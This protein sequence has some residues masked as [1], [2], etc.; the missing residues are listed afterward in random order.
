MFFL[1]EKYNNDNISLTGFKIQDFFDKEFITTAITIYKT[2]LNVNSFLFDDEYNIFLSSKKH[3]SILSNFLLKDE[4]ILKQHIKNHES[5]GNLNN[6]D[7]IITDLNGFV[8]GLI[9]ILVQNYK[10]GTFVIVDNSKGFFTY[11]KIKYMCES[12]NIKY[13]KYIKEYNFLS[14]Y[15]DERFNSIVKLYS[16]C[17]CIKKSSKYLHQIMNTQD[18]L[19]NSISSSS[20]KSDIKDELTSACKTC[21]EILDIDISSILL[22]NINNSSFEFVEESYNYN[23]VLEDF[24]NT[25]VKNDTLNI[26]DISSDIETYI[27]EKNFYIK[28][29]N[30]EVKNKVIGYVFLIKANKSISIN[31]IELSMLKSIIKLVCINYE[32]KIADSDITT[33]YF[34]NI[35]DNMNVGIYIK[36]CKSGEIVYVNKFF[37]NQFNISSHTENSNL[38]TYLNLVTEEGDFYYNELDKW[39]YNYKFMTKWVD[40]REV[41]L[42]INIE[43]TDA[44]KKHLSVKRTKFNSTLTSLPNRDKLLMDLNKIYKL[45][46]DNYS[47]IILNVDFFSRIN[48]SYGY[49]YGDKFI[50]QIT[51]FLKGLD[52]SYTTYHLDGSEFA[53]IINGSEVLVQ[54]INTILNRFKSPWLVENLEHYCTASIGVA[55]IPLDGNSSETL[56]QN[57]ISALKRAKSTGRNKA[58]YFDPSLD[59]KFIKNTQLEYYLRSAVMKNIEYFK[60]YYQPIVDAKTGKI[61]SIESLVRWVDPEVGFVPPDEFISLAE[62]LGFINII[63]NYVLETACKF[64]KSLHDLGHY[65][66]VSVNLSTN[67]LYEEDFIRYIKTTIESTGLDCSYVVLEVTESTAITDIPN[68]IKKLKEL[69]D[70][71]IKVSLDDFG[72]GYS[73][74]N[75]LKSLPV[76]TVKIDKQF[77]RDL[78][79]SEYNYTF[80]K[81]IIELAHTANLK[82]CCEGIETFEEWN[83]LKSLGC[84]I[85]QGYYFSRPLQEDKLREKLLLQSH[86]N[87]KKN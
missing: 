31:N 56:T 36:E 62:Y 60:V 74:L 79:N 64:T 71:G 22:L 37:L 51:K 68:A 16:Q 8:I 86:D 20:S 17:F 77:I 47:F 9:P 12:N 45:N 13:D 82:V 27:K 65:I 39:F 21:L 18:F 83:I 75:I 19:L 48:F 61:L 26:E 6:K 33:S 63:D 10:I 66:T 40:D 24:I 67:Q 4:E 34:Y 1:N 57:A 87:N 7:Y 30:I 2:I 32:Y 28:T 41:E 14:D 69:K 55:R 15:Q 73:S 81:T 70:L 54:K 25:K 35:L 29:Y 78:Q 53:L 59:D 43:N 85:L 84:D 44:T 38:L 23:Y 46:C 52:S 58:C 5:N 80:I 42:W 49:D 3:N 72:T 11:E 76:N 50:L